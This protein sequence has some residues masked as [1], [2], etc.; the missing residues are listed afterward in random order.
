MYILGMES[1]QLQD[2]QLTAY[3]YTLG[4]RSGK[5]SHPE[6]ARLVDSFIIRNNSAT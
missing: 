2:Y 6:T 4:P 5:M 3:D 1:G